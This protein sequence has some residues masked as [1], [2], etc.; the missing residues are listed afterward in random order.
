MWVSESSDWTTQICHFLPFCRLSLAE[1]C[2]GPASRVQECQ[3]QTEPLMASEA[4]SKKPG[5]RGYICGLTGVS[6]YLKTEMV[7]LAIFLI[8]LVIPRG[9][10][11]THLVSPPSE[12]QEWT[13]RVAGIGTPFGSLEK[14]QGCLKDCA[15]APE[16]FPAYHDKIMGLGS[17][18]H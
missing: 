17:T 5:P 7:T 6:F 16:F 2:G 11:V 18:Q 12:L 14:A 15:E 8:H 9:A 4:L 13:W 1:L 3:E 10:K